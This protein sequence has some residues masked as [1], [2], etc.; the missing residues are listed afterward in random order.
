MPGIIKEKTP[1]FAIVFSGENPNVYT[2]HSGDIIFET[3]Y[4]YMASIPNLINISDPNY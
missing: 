2:S 1:S 4:N 3:P